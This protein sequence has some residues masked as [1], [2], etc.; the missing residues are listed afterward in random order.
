MEKQ[1]LIA[2]HGDEKIKRKYLAR[3]KSHRDADEIIKGQY[4]QEGRGCAVGCTLHS[5][6][7]SAYEDELGIPMVLARLED[8]IFEG[9]SNETAKDFPIRFLESIQV[10]ADLSMVTYKFMHW[11]LVNDEYGV[12]NFTKRE[13][14]KAAIQAVA[15]KFTKVIDGET[16]THDEWLDVMRAAYAADAADDAAYASA[17]DAYADAAAYTSAAAYDRKSAFDAQAEKLLELLIE[18]K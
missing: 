18:A 9:M 13:E 17:S 7:H 4:W 5:K 12:I 8:R 16:V 11:L 15:D 3:V 10:G 1:K 14:S 6:N 2:F